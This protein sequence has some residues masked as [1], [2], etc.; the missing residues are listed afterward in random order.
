MVVVFMV[1]VCSLGMNIKKQIILT[2]F[3]EFHRTRIWQ[4]SGTKLSKLL[5]CHLNCLSHGMQIQGRNVDALIQ[6]DNLKGPFCVFRAENA[7]CKKR[8]KGDKRVK[9]YI[10]QLYSWYNL[11]L[12]F[13]RI[14]S[15]CFGGF[16]DDLLTLTVTDYFGRLPK[17]ASRWI[18]AVQRVSYKWFKK[19][20]YNKYKFKLYTFE[21]VSL[22]VVRFP[23]SLEGQ[24]L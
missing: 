7:A 22:M 17:N 2:Q 13:L 20:T 3:E 15:G 14:F 1:V 21:N 24:V 16:G 8:E 9:N 4:K 11:I 19:Y 12:S 5:H 6:A 23:N 18:C 10:K